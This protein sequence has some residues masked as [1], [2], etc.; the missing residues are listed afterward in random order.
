MSE[1]NEKVEPQPIDL[2]EYKFGFHDDVKPIYSTGKGL[3]EAV[4]RE[5]SAAK[6]EPGW[7]LDFRL[8]SLET[9]NKMPMQTWGADLSDIDFDDII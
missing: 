7:M 8:K 3:N 2:G 6:G 4:I 9:F 5:L 1:I